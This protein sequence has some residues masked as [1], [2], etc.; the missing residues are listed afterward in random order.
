MT[1]S[2]SAESI[3]QALEGLED[4]VEYAERLE[5][6][7]TVEVHV[8]DLYEWRDAVRSIVEEWACDD[9]GTRKSTCTKGGES[10]C[11]KC[12]GL[13][14]NDDQLVTDG[15]EEETVLAETQTAG[16][17][18]ANG[19]VVDRLLLDFDRD[20]PAARVR[21]ERVRH[22]DP[23]RDD[24]VRRESRGTMVVNPYDTHRDQS[25]L[26]IGTSH[27][28]DRVIAEWNEHAPRAYLRH[29]RL[30]DGDWTRQ[31][32]WELHPVQG[33]EQVGGESSED[34]ELV[35]DGGTEEHGQAISQGEKN[36]QKGERHEQQA[37]R[38]LNARYSAQ[39]VPSIY[40]NN[41]PFH[42]ADLMGLKAGYP[43]ALVQVKTNRFTA[44]DKRYYRKWAH[45]RVD[46]EHTIFE[47]WVRE[48]RT[49]W[50]MHRLDPETREFTCY[51]ETSTCDPSKV[52]EDWREAF[53]EV[54]DVDE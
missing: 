26:E 48:D 24:D 6:E 11:N 41:D 3:Q 39:R 20:T 49:G 22:P 15:G 10:F 14:L 29:E 38:I 28:R 43:F 32:A 1:V 8:T 35:T 42:L 2:D 47:L 4:K 37:S 30:E 31:A 5:I 9:C 50:Q 12:A 52:R 7:P 27:G 44:E 18:L 17:G 54:T 45:R 46:G 25:K 40:G 53:M 21:R 19:K 36:R 13:T 16:F 34:G 23:M 51:F 33:V